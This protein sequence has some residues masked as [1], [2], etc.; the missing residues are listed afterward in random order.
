[1]LWTHKF[2]SV[3]W[4]PLLTTGGANDRMF[5]DMA[6]RDADGY[7]HPVDR[8]SNMIISGGEYNY[9]PRSMA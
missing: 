5:R 8:K 7:I 6:R 3:I 4:A 2:P 1:M 9:C